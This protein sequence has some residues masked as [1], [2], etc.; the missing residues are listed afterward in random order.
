MQTDILGALA[1]G[2]LILAY[3]WSVRSLARLS[4][5]RLND[6]AAARETLIVIDGVRRSGHTPAHAAADETT[7]SRRPASGSPA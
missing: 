7:T 3:G 5:R 2:W 4:R 1:W 6:D